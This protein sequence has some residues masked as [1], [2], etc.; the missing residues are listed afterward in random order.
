M[1]QPIE[2]DVVSK[3]CQYAKTRNAQGLREVT[4][5]RSVDCSFGQFNA[6]YELALEGS[7]SAVNA[8][9]YL[10]QEWDANINWAMMGAGSWKY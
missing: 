4:E 3:I 10:H 1:Q 5:G 2:I 9:D 8:I 7:T 6:M